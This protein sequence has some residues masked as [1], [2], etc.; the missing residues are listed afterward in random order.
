[1]FSN[2][3][4][5]DFVLQL[6]SLNDRFWS[7][8]NDHLGPWSSKHLGNIIGILIV[9]WAIRRFGG[10]LAMRFIST[11]V[12]HDLYP[13]EADRKKR[14]KTLQSL[15]TAIFRVGT[16]AIALLLIISEIRPNYA[17]TLFA[18]AG[19]IGVA[20]GFGAQSLIKDFMSGIF[21]ILEN[22][23]RV[24][25]TVTLD[26]VSGTV[27]GITMR[28]TILRDA[29][30]SVHHVPNGTI[31]VTTNKTMDYGR[32][33]ELLVVD[34]DTDLDKFEKMIN[35]IGKE[36]ADMPDFESRLSQPPRFDRVN[37]LDAKG[38]L[39][40]RI[41]AKTSPSDQW[42]VKSEFYRRLRASAKKTNIK[43]HT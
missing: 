19:I 2:L 36:M 16:W 13:T 10:K 9:A 29:D 43:L 23:Y 41:T 21:I 33:N 3:I 34:A 24:G 30:G 15:V 35:N 17:G 38:D 27:E 5:S 37:G 6:T 1:M 11:T 32:M 40:V 42:K 12:R 14:I 39:I 28:T 25:D 7:W 4:T 31:T 26:K 22:Q 20:I 8:I 18:S